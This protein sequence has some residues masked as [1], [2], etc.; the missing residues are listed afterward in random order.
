[1]PGMIVA[2]QPEAAEAGADI[3]A[4]GGNAIDAAIAAAPEQGGFTF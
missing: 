4:R 2:P 3:L 1:M